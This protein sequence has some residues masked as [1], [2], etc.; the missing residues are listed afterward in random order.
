MDVSKSKVLGHLPVGL[1]GELMLAFNDIVKNFRNGKWG[2]TELDGG[3]LCEVVYSILKGYTDGSYPAKASKPRDM[4]TACRQLEQTASTF[5]R[6]VRIQIP[7]VIVA[8]YEVRNNRGVGH[9]G[10]EVDPNHMDAVMVLY[11]ARWIMAELIR[12]FHDVDIPTATEVVEALT[13]REVPLI[14]SVNGQKRILSG[15]LKTKEKVLLLLYSE[16]SSSVSE[17]DLVAWTEHSNAAVF[18]RDILVKGHKAR[19]WEYDKK[20]K[21]VSLSPLGA[22]EV[23]TKLL[24]K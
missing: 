7:R 4:V 12:I 9:V 21:T 23:E 6:S 18:R 13:E 5:P 19:L 15:N 3:K 1:R 17:A 8:L 22:S 20:S 2:P 16:T 14:W 24:N 11:N 10:G